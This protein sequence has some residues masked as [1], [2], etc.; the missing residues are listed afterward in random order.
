MKKSI[1]S[2]PLDNEGGA[3]L[4]EWHSVWKDLI[5]GYEGDLNQISAAMEGLA[6][7][8]ILSVT[9]AMGVKGDPRDAFETLLDYAA[10]W[11][12]LAGITRGLAALNNNND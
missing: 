11:I 9:V 5:E 12:D 4:A 7:G 3:A 10:S 1:N 8:L 2:L 6:S